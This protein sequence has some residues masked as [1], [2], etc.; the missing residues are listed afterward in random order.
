MCSKVLETLFSALADTEG[1]APFM[2]SNK[3]GSTSIAQAAEVDRYLMLSSGY[4][5]GSGSFLLVLSSPLTSLCCH[6][7]VSLQPHT[8]MPFGYAS[9]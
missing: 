6:S 9:R 5:P 8:R 2:S 1:V 3:Y 4:S 7:P